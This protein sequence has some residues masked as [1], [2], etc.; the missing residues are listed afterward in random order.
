[1]I[2]RI[3]SIIIFSIVFILVFSF[4]ANAADMSSLEDSINSLTDSL[5]DEVKEDM[6]GLGV[7]SP[8]INSINKISFSSIMELI[9][10]KL[11]ENSKAPFSASAAVIAIIILYAL[12]DSYKDVLRQSTMKE[13]LSVISTL[14]IVATLIVPVIRL[15]DYSIATVKEAS[16]FMLVYL[17]VMVG[18]LAFSGQA[19]SSAGYY[20]MMIV[21]CQAVSQLSSKFIAPLL[22][23]FLGFSVS[24]A[25]T[26]RINL[27]GFCQMFSKI[28]KWLI[29]FV[30]TLF[31]AM[32]TIRSLITTAYDSITTR[33][34]RFTLSSFIPIVGTA[35]SEAYKTIQ[36]SIN[37]LRSGAGVF[38][39]LAI[40]VVFLPS[41]ARC[42]MWLLSINLCKAIAQTVGVDGPCDLLAAVSS[43]ISTI[44]AIIVCIMAIFIISTALLIT[45]GGK[46]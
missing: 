38:V 26:D 5:S 32:L 2:K 14:S 16:N 6:S 44:F 10:Q 21:V 31:S 33:A 28:I 12:L 18:I 3:L 11:S 25:I 24:S 20:S 40:F 29:S 8:D 41:I 9:T 1:M 7:T 17:P 45:L 13:V 42:F 19:V 46:T 37:L 36:G 27:K 22:N 39:I 35:I 4:S 30:M 43:V 23:V 34:V 15:I